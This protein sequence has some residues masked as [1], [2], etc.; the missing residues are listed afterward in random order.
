MAEGEV[1][2]NSVGRPSKVTPLVVQKLEYA[3]ALGC[4]DEEACF[5]ADISKQTLYNYQEK[6]PG[7]IDRKEALKTRPIFLARETLLKGLQNDPDLALKMLERKR[8]DEFG[9]KP[10]AELNITLPQPILGSASV[11]RIEDVPTQE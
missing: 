6:N 2:K 10:T 9:L 4:T 1:V 8:K 11:K 3:F 5:Y 7:F